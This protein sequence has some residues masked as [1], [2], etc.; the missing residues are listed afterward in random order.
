M[1]EFTKASDTHAFGMLF[2]RCPVTVEV[3]IIYSS[4]APPFRTT[5][6]GGE[7]PL[8][9][10][11]TLNSIFLP[12][13]FSVDGSY[14]LC[15]YPRRWRGPSARCDRSVLFLGPT[16]SNIPVASIVLRASINR[17]PPPLTTTAHMHIDH[18]RTFPQSGR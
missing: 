9:V 12:P 5:S 14:L 17:F 4:R 8:Q 1:S 13:P 7:I 15:T 2:T 18:V 6:R 3:Y 10:H 11:I 16:V